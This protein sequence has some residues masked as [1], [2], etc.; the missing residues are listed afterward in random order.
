MF[1]SGSAI[2]RKR[3]TGEFKAEC[4]KFDDGSLAFFTAEE[5]KVRCTN[6]SCPGVSGCE[7]CCHLHTKV[8]PTSMRFT[9]T[10][11]EFC[12]R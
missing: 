10:K 12:Y 2:K 8:Y 9:H 1:S 4:T 11:G 7:K 5:A 6:K 3:H